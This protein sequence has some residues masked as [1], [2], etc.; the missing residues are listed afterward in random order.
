[1]SIVIRTGLGIERPGPGWYLLGSVV[2]VRRGEIEPT[3]GANCPPARTP[4]SKHREAA[5]GGTL[6]VRRVRLGPEVPMP[7]GR[8]L[9]LLLAALAGADV[10]ASRRAAHRRTRGPS[11]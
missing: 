7:T 1:M 5:E 9:F 10:L 8:P 6:Q 4:A 3:A 11:R 2:R